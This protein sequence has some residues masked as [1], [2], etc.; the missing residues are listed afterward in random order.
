LYGLP[1][2]VPVD[3]VKRVELVETGGLELVTELA[4]VVGAEE[5]VGTLE[6]VVVEVR[7]SAYTPAARMMITITAMITT[8]DVFIIRE[9]QKVFRYKKLNFF[10]RSKE[11]LARDL[12]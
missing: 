8:T 5:V 3:V 12:R 6:V 10:S 1:V 7:V 2:A 9:R 11:V 4:V